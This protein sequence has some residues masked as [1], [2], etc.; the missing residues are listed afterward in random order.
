[1]IDGT[2]L[3][4]IPPIVA[5]I[6]TYIVASKKARVQYAKV[7]ADMQSKAVEVVSAQEEKMR[8]E[9]WA[10]L[11]SVRDE[12]QSLREELASLKEKLQSSYDL[13]DSLR[14]EIKS[15]KSALEATTRELD[16]SKQRIVELENK[17]PD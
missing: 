17:K 16:I 15:L 13:S 11:A 2:I 1:M 12:N 4:I 5:S 3:A 10:E 6:L 9:I 8:Q 14:E 7:V